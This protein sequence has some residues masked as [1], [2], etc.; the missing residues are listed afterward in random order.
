M[1][2]C[3]VLYF[4]LVTG[5]FFVLHGKT[6]GFVL[7]CF[8]YGLLICNLTVNGRIVM[9]SGRS[10]I[11]G[12]FNRLCAHLKNSLACVYYI[13]EVRHKPSN[14]EDFIEDIVKIINGRYKGLSGKK[15][16][17]KK[18]KKEHAIFL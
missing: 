8:I 9:F 16:L 2:Y 4:S 14:N 13:F 5:S 12:L 11:I 17:K 10:R 6:C 15:C 1:N 7:V 18:K 3:V